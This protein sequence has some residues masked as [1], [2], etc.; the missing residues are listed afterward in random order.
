MKRLVIAALVLGMAGCSH[1]PVE[2]PKEHRLEGIVVRLDAEHHRATIKHQKIEGWMEAMTME[3]PVRDE[4]G[5]AK[6][7]VGAPVQAKVLE[8]ASTFEYWLE[9]IQIIPAR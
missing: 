8:R 7:R 9:D 1:K 4:A 3:F 5:F 2:A 6:L